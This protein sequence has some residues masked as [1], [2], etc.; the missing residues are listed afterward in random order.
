MADYTAQIESIY[1]AY[2][3]RPA[4]VTG[5]AYWNTALNTAKGDLASIINSFGTSAE[6]TSLYSSSSNIAK[7]NAIYVALFNRSA[8]AEGLIYYAGLLDNGTK[9]QAS[10]ALDI[11]NGATGDDLTLITKKLVVS[12]DFTAAMQNDA[13]AMIAY[14]GTTAATTA[15]SMLSAVTATSD[16][17]GV[18]S[19]TL[20]TIETVTTD[21]TT[22]A[23]QTF[24]LT[25]GTNKFT[26]DS[27]DDTFDAGLSTS[28]LQTLN[29]G[30]TLDGGTGTDTLYAVVIGSATPTLTN[31]ENVAIT[32]T[33]TSTI[34]FTNATGVSSIS[35]T[36]STVALTLSGIS[37]S[38]PA[39]TVRDTS[40]AF[41]QVVNYSDVTGSADS[42]TVVINNVS[43]SAALS[44]PGVETL[45]LESNGTTA[46]V[47]ATLTS[48]AATKV[49]VTGVNGLTV[50]AALG[51]T[52]TQ[53]DASANTGT[54]ITA[55]MATTTSNTITGSAG[56]DSLTIVSTNADSC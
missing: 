41:T 34:D 9:S 27:G 32:A 40:A 45:T 30:D 33:T 37:A 2:Y 39:V 1:L 22:A 29:S 49:N 48:A 5:L 55:I 14:A 52:V 12:A 11:L 18:V 21:T 23:A 6:A 28:S 26:G 42:A 3:G 56:N 47:L 43:G 50:T 54:G 38:G 46:N 19:T 51:S 31:I 4:D 17:S 15:R 13:T 16:D 7:I 20:T 8:D 36:G 53:L 25:T 44:V 10:I 24:T 35:N